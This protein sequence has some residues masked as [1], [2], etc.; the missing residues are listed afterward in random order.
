MLP[1]HLSLG[2]F[3]AALG[4]RPQ[5]VQGTA[6][7]GKKLAA[8]AIASLSGSS[9]TTS[10]S[11]PTELPDENSVIQSVVGNTSDKSMTWDKDIKW[12]RSVTNMKIVVKGLLTAEDALLAC[13]A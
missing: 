11:E 3:D 13:K 1:P 9:S 10:P 8:A 7:E 12:L 5:S 2:N 6:K 4:I